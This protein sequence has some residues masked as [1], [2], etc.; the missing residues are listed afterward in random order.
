MINAGHKYSNQYD[1][2]VPDHQAPIPVDSEEFGPKT[3]GMHA[4]DIALVRLHQRDENTAQQPEGS[5]S[6]LSGG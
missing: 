4:G 1:Q 5:R 2:S 3:R 6:V